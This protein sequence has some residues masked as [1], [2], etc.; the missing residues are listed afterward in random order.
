[1]I[2]HDEER[3][4]RILSHILSQQRQRTGRA[5]CLDEEVLASYLSG[6]LTG[7]AKENLEAHLA[8]CT[9]CLDDLVAVHKAVEDKGVERVPQRVIDRAMS[10]VS[11]SQRG[12]EL[13]DLVVR[14]VKD[15]VELVRT[16]GQLILSPAPVGVRGRPK[17][18]QTS[19]LQVEKEMGRFKVTVEVERVETELCQVA[20]RVRQEGGRP[21][22]GIRL[23]L[24][25][26]GREQAS[27]LTRKGEVVFDPIPQGDYNLAI[28]DSGTPVGTIRLRLTA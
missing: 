10:L 16:S 3:I 20:V 25:S 7:D 5:G 21:A 14:V 8:T 17:P 23:S 4:G 1:M 18:S 26:G 15:T 24:V 6:L 2:D 9:M 27:Y 19:I 11:P 12:E 28:S 13:L 22:D